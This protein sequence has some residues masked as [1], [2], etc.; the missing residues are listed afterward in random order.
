MKISF[1]SFQLKLFLPTICLLFVFNSADAQD[2]QL[3]ITGTNTTENDAINSIGYS[4]THKDYEALKLQIDS[5]KNRAYK[6]GYIEAKVQDI[7]KTTL[8]V[9]VQLSLGPK[10]ESIQ[11]HANK[12]LFEFLELTP[13]EDA[14]KKLYYLSDIQGLESLLNS[15]TNSLASKSYPFGT[16][17]LK[18]IR[19]IDK[20]T[21]KADLSLDTKQARQL[22]TVEIKGYDKFP[23]SFITHFLGIKTKRPFDLKAI[24]AK[25]E[26]LNQLSFVK[27]LRS[28]EVL[29]TKDTTSVYLYLEKN[30]SNRFEGFL[31]FGSEET[32]G[33]LE[34]NG[35]LNL[36][37]INNLNYGE[38]FVLNYRSDENDLKTFNTKLT[39]PYLFR[40]P[41]GTELKLSIFKK[42]ST[43]TTAEQSANLY[44][45]LNPKQKLFLGVK[46][47]QSNSLDPIE[48]STIIDYK[49]SAYELRYAYQN[50]TPKD[51][52][53]PVKSEIEAQL[54]RASRKTEA[55]KTNQTF[56]LIKASHLFKFNS[57]NSLYINLNTQGIDS[58]NYLSNELLRFGGIKTIRGFEE[59]SI[60]ASAFGVIASEYRLRLSPTLYIHSII[61]AAY[62]NTPIKEGQKLI[63]LGFGFG[64]ATQAGLLKFNL[65]NGQ[66]E[67]Q[68]F[69]FSDSKVHLSLTA[70]F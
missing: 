68:N 36:N 58:K 55:A 33:A 39:L 56:L 67:N 70:R 2:L 15:I 29:F 63:G 65:A 8:T 30:K 42:D 50:R 66:T 32:T 9:S 57:S 1:V 23:R 61:D 28:A 13:K 11:I 49:T 41:I 16:V 47:A 17:S 34:L 40:S 51:L 52:L 64:L 54:S 44:Y 24:Q 53:F 3:A 25:T 38:S 48:S 46:T 5:F 43:F 45:Q 6:L 35:Y 69:K 19:P 60:N 21:L 18:N 22:N 59:N 20:A 37:L 26:A 31:G 4:K 12:S 7:T 10:Y 14:D 27:Q 62:F